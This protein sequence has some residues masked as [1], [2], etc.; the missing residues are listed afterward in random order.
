MR[1][2]A[3]TMGREKVG[4]VG[5]SGS[6]KSMTARAILGLVRKPGEVRAKR[7]RLGGTDLTT[8]SPAG[9]RALR[10][11]RAGGFSHQIVPPRSPSPGNGCPSG[12]WW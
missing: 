2:F 5:E 1:D 7:M 6:G 3:L 11:K 10:G 4:I 12:G 8:L 9:Y